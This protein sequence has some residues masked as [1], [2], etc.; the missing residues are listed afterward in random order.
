MNKNSLT[1]D[2]LLKE[3]SKK[4]IE[5]ENL[6]INEEYIFKNKNAEE[7][8]IR[9]MKDSNNKFDPKKKYNISLNEFKIKLDKYYSKYPPPP[10]PS[11]SLL[12]FY[13][14]K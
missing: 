7:H 8:Y 2:D 9:V 14:N 3:Y 11:R 1:I 5:V 10:H 12:F 13:K 4:D 6:K